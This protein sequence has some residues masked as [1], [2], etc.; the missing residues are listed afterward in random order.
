M[1][2]F[3]S[4]IDIIGNRKKKIKLLKTCQNSPIDYYQFSV[5]YKINEIS[6]QKLIR[7]GTSDFG[8]SLC[9]YIHSKCTCIIVGL[10][11]FLQ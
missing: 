2:E 4:F 7:H 5:K 11:D 1:A 9:G 8:E 3:G 10:R 6:G